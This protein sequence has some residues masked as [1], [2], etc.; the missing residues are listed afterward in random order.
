MSISPFSYKNYDLK[1]EGNKNDISNAEIHNL[2]VQGKLT[3]DELEML[4]LILK[5]KYLNSHSIKTY[6]SRSKEVNNKLSPESIQRRLKKLNKSGMLVRYYF[7]HLEED[8]SILKRTANFYGLSRGAF[9]YLRKHLK[10]KENS[11]EYFNLPT[12]TEL[13]KILSVNQLVINFMLKANGV[14]SCSMHIPLHAKSYH[15]KFTVM[16]SCKVQS[17]FTTMAYIEAVRRNPNWKVELKTRLDFIYDYIRYEGLTDTDLPFVILIGEDD[18]HIVQMQREVVSMSPL[19]ELIY[20]TTDASMTVE[21][22]ESSLFKVVTHNEKDFD[23]NEMKID[24]LGCDEKDIRLVD[25]E[26]FV[27]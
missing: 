20:F 2:K 12:V 9:E 26:D 15:K 4:E 6:F 21:S 25:S 17:E 27:V 24:F 1:V 10:Y 22:L 7:T 16:A 5:Y 8:G 23:I 14:N 19:R 18:D 11:N 13:L 3:G